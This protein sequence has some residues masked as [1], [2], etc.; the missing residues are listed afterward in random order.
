[1][2]I[3]TEPSLI[4]HGQNEFWNWQWSSSQPSDA[5]QS[6]IIQPPHPAPHRILPPHVCATQVESI[7]VPPT[8]QAFEE[9]SPG[10]S[11]MDVGH[12]ASQQ[13][14]V[15]SYQV[16]SELPVDILSAQPALVAQ[17]H[18]A[19]QAAPHFQPDPSLVPPSYVGSADA[20]PT[21]QDICAN[22]TKELRQE[23]G[24]EA[25][26]YSLMYAPEA[27][28]LPEQISYLLCRLHCRLEMAAIKHPVLGCRLHDFFIKTEANLKEARASSLSS[29][30]DAAGVHLY[31]DYHLGDLIQKISLRVD[32]L[33]DLTK[34]KRQAPG[35]AQ[36]SQALSAE[37]LSEIQ[38]PPP[39]A[40]VTIDD[41][42]QAIPLYEQVPDQKLQDQQPT[43]AAS[44]G[45]DGQQTIP[46]MQP[47][48]LVMVPSDT[49]LVAQ[50]LQ[51]QPTHLVGPRV[52]KASKRPAHR[53]N[54]PYTKEAVDFLNDVFVKN[55]GNIPDHS[56]IRCLAGSI[57][58]TT[59]QIRKWFSNK[60]NRLVKNQEAKE[61]RQPTAH[62][63]QHRR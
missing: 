43:S 47:V 20:M 46:M 28:A 42:Q 50:P 39:M 26:P 16:Q 4:G 38:Q 44:I 15:P 51:Q 35:V 62:A 3:I 57:G 53:T 6:S 37:V 56:A 48:Q 54:N 36:T 27:A 7:R 29:G 1:M 23:F 45:V 25:V 30:C 33:D 22:L 58:M 52:K 60:R 55:N 40:T 12:F 10:T 11:A 59:Q 13:N 63:Q 5:V 41:G 17:H 18:P 2:E 61:N 34:R 14:V 31:Y 49:P 21:G 19:Q 8:Q 9:V 24:T 32:L